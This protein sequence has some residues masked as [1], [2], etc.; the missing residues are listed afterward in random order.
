M[1]ALPLPLT[2]IRTCWSGVAL[3]EL[4][5][6]IGRVPYGSQP[7]IFDFYRFTGPGTR[8]FTDNIPANSAYFSLDG[9]NTKL[10]DFGVSSDPSD[11]LNA[12][13][14]NL[15]P[16]D[17]FDEFYSGSTLQSLTS[18]DLEMLDAL[19][20]NTHPLG[21]SVVANTAQALQGGPAVS[22]LTAAPSINDP[23]STTL[24]GATIKIAN[25]GGN[26]VAGDELFV[27]G[28]Q[29]GAL[30]GVTASWNST[31]DTLTLSGAAS[32][33]VYD[34]LL[35]E[36]TFQDTGTDTSSGS[37]PVR[38][39]TWSINDGTNSY[40][41]TSQ[42]TLDRAPV[43][44]NNTATDAVGTTLTTTAASGVLSND[45]DLDGDK[46]TVT[47][48]SDT[49][50]GTGTV[51][52]ALA[53]LYGHLTLNADGSYSYVA[54]NTGAIGSASNGLLHDSFTYT[55][56]DGNG[57]TSSAVLNIAVERPPVVTTSNI[58]ENPGLTLAA[59]SL[60][61]VSDPNGFAI[62]EYQFWD[63]TS[64]P[65]SGHFYFNGVL[66]PDHTLLDV[67]AAQLSEVT[68]VTGTDPNAL[69]VRAF[70]G[71]SWSAAD[72]AVWAPFNVTITTPPPP[73]VTTSNLTE[74]PSVTLA[75]SSLFTVSDPDNLPITEYQFWDRTSDPASG[76]FYLN[77]VLVPDHTL[78]DVT[79]AQLSEV[80]FVTGTD[81]NA[82]EVRAFDGVSWSAADNAVWAPFN[83][84]IAAPPPPV[85]TTSNL[86]ENPSVTLAASSLFTV[87]DPD[88]LP[89]TEYQFWDRT[90]DPASG[91][92]YLNGVLVPDHTLLDVT[93]AQLSEV[94][95]VTGT[96]SNALEVRAFDG[97]SWS[98]ADNAVWAPFNINIAAPPSPV[99][100][101]SN[102][103]ENPGV[104]LAASSLFTVSDP[105][106]LAITEYQFWDRTSDPAS[107][108]FYL[109]GVRVPDHTLL[110][111]A[112]AQLSEVTFV[113]GTDPNALEVRAFDGVSWSAADNAVWAPFNV[114]IATP[115]PPLVTTSNLTEGP[116]QT[117]AASSLFTVSDPDNLAITEY[118]FW[119]RT[120]DPASGHFYFN[121]VLVPDH[122]LLDVTAAQLSEVTF[123]TGTDSNA[124]EVRAF[125]GVSWSAADNAV[126]APFN[127]NIPA[128]A[129]ALPATTAAPAETVALSTGVVPDNFIFAPNFGQATIT[130]FAPASN[131]IQIDHTMFADVSALLE[132]THDDVNGNAVITDAQHDTITIKNVTTAQLL[133]HQADFHFV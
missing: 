87:S 37:H 131:T 47:G 130:N 80:T 106:H 54:D 28:I 25:A 104:T 126:W 13:N 115:P 48:V 15:T 112:A 32:V 123:V 63:R 133:A 84:N 39:V 88:N 4:T 73:V 18:V 11:F 19:G 8:L 68:F 20:F 59:S 97:V 12:P 26:A 24:S 5:H 118:Q 128:T 85:V 58:S 75:A 51:G 43:A 107:G 109:N 16:T 21:L 14:S 10:A 92:F 82:L 94:T 101:T 100:T 38:T 6:A 91:H 78:L 120:S 93:A 103:T 124:L 42:A 65:A 46:L 83:I 57:G 9:G 81:S 41:A 49:A 96:D 99:V 3:H 53:G 31:T 45:A 67:T 36:V 35:S 98:A 108:H 33:A 40:T 102:L 110:D 34:T 2:S 61:A 132:A 113:T 60:F 29:N 27:N 129:P 127:V 125:D 74:N 71:V 7:D 116:N 86:T 69:E 52:S 72:N 122:T 121:G 111:V 89:I 70:D 23:G 95:F 119:D 17:A 55:V 114:N 79:A 1:A 44:V 50:Q 77:G 30:S 66:V 105:D 64:D 62:T 90:S 117:L 22:L 76:H 56:S